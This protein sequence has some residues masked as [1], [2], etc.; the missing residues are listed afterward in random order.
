MN[1][2][3]RKNLS[4]WFCKVI[5]LH[6]N[7]LPIKKKAKDFYQKLI[8][9]SQ[10]MEIRNYLIWL[11][12]HQ[13]ASTYYFLNLIN[14]LLL[15]LKCFLL[16]ILKINYLMLLRIYSL[17][18]KIIISFF[19][20]IKRKSNLLCVLCHFSICLYINLFISYFWVLYFLFLLN[21]SFLSFW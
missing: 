12:F 3:Y 10:L 17:F 13:F 15:N 11:I 8:L 2:F 7:L 5:L 19:N 6:F 9:F 18:L 14:F 20:Y 16:Y 4:F 21:L 1:I